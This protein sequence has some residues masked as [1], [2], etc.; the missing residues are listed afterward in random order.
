MSLHTHRVIISIRYPRVGYAHYRGTGVGNTDK[1]SNNPVLICC[2]G[3][4]AYE[5][6]IPVV[7]LKYCSI[8]V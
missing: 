6:C 1:T 7:D 5:W 2:E 3:K 4:T 8:Y